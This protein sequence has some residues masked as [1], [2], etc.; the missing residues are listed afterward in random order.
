MRK[1]IEGEGEASRRKKRLVDIIKDLKKEGDRWGGGIN[2]PTSWSSSFWGDRGKAIGGEGNT[3]I[4]KKGV[5]AQKKKKGWRA[6]KGLLLS[7]EEA[8]RSS[9]CKEVARR[10]KAKQGD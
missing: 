4:E 8:I 10:R 3:I 9:H 5:I 1:S 2:F 6:K 7:G